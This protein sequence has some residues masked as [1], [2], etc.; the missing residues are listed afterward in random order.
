MQI[1]DLLKASAIFQKEIVAK[2]LF[3]KPCLNFHYLQVIAR[4]ETEHVDTMEYSIKNL[5]M[6]DLFKVGGIFQCFFPKKKLP[7]SIF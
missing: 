5:Q 4:L 7:N 2:F 1:Q 3:L 6:L